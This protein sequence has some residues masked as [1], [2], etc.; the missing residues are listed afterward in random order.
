[1]EEAH[2]LV[3]VGDVAA[4][5]DWSDM[6]GLLGEMVSGEVVSLA[7]SSPHGPVF[8]SRR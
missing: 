1:M 5:R 8:H 6:R 3:A 7:F 4:G 2:H